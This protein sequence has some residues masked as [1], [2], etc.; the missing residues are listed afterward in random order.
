MSHASLI[1]DVEDWLVGKALG[2]PDIRALFEKLC[3][4]LRAT[5]IP[6]ARASLSWPTLHP[7][8][9]S[10][11]VFWWHGKG[12]ELNQYE[13]TN[14]PTEAWLNSPL[15]YAH[16]HRLSHLRRQLTG[17]D[18]MLDFPVLED[19]RD[20][21]YT[22]YLVTLTQF[23][24]ADVIDFAG[25]NTGLIASWL[26]QR[27]GGFSDADLDAFRRIKR[28]FAVAVRASIQRRVMDNIA[29]AYLG[30]TAG[31][32]VLKGDIRRGDGARVPAVV[33]YSDLRSSTRLSD[34][35]DP[36]SYLALL[37]QYFECTA[38]PIIDHGGEILNF[39]GDGVLGVFPIEAKCPMDA[40]ARAEAAV[41]A[42]L[43]AQTQAEKTGTPGGAPLR[44]GIG[45]GIG[46]VKF[47]N[48]G[49]P[50]RLAFSGIGKIVNAV[51]RIES[52]TKH[53]DVPVLASEQY[54]EAAPGE[55][56]TAGEIEIPDF[57]KR[58]DVYT[59]PELIKAGRPKEKAARTP[60]E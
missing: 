58:M 29:T 55:W 36:D 37:N 31:H 23:G 35:M 48:I 42:A 19:F 26:T 59:L 1:A 51:Q 47:G 33:W 9:K 2:D 10:E 53:L 46:E 56:A 11:Q 43:D 38:Q 34:T 28:M 49:V 60:A 40:A 8:F 13:H 30:P 32:Q 15:Y 7:L 12:S 54:A 16:K 17:P 22:D 6:L 57:E 5:G 20:Q 3:D 39:I 52:N 18:A 14:G 4:R 25:R 44:F 21:G 41:R 45:L 24:I 50:S 27:E